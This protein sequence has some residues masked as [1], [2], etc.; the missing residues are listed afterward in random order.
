MSDRKGRSP[1]SETRR[2]ADQLERAF[3][4]EAWHGPSLREVLAQVTAPRAAAR[5]IP[6]AHTIGEIAA[7]VAAWE[8]AVRRRLEGELVELSEAQDWPR[9]DDTGE[10]AWKALLA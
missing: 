4:G 9:I 8:D 10:A 2:I 5:P 6:S 7:H 3:E 1:V